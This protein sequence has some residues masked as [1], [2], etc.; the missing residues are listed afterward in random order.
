M[1]L[2]SAYEGFLYDLASILDHI[3][4]ELGLKVTESKITISQKS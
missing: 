3:E 4:A 1:W 2:E